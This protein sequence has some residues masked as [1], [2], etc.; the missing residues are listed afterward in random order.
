MNY[1]KVI[2]KI[3]AVAATVNPLFPLRLA[4]RTVQSQATRMMYGVFTEH[5]QSLP[6][7]ISRIM[8]QS[9]FTPRLTLIT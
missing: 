6:Q 1:P 4:V 5:T 3:F 7:F 2:G 9:I 8:P